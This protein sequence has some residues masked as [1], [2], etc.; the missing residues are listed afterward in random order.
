MAR[1]H[2]HLVHLLARVH[3]HERDDLRM[4]ARARACVCVLCV[5]EARIKGGQS[6][7]GWSEVVSVLPP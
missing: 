7:E 3:D 1:C 4:R 2:A 6:S 5:A